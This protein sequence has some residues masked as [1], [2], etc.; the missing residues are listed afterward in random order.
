MIT[1]LRRMQSGL[2]AV[3][4]WAH[5]YVANEAASVEEVLQ[6]E[7]QDNGQVLLN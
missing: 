5:F 7:R 3:V 4:F 6:A 1:I 2:I